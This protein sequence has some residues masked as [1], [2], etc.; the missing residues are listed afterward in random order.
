MKYY[1]I[2]QITNLINGKIYIG[3]HETKIPND[4]YMGSGKN[5]KG[6]INK[7]GLENFKK[8]IL[9][10]F[11]TEEEMNFKEAELVT[12][13]FCSRVDTY[14]I[15]PG[16]KGGW[17]YLNKNGLNNNGKDYNKIGKKLKGRKYPSISEMMKIRHKEGKVKYDTFLG[18]SHSEQTKR[19]MSLKA[20][21]RKTNSQSGTMWITNGS[22]NKKIKNIDIMPDGWYKGR[23]ATQTKP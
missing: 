5:I 16:G 14:N 7:Y 23:I 11:N 20:K 13:D 8:D 15:C 12:E 2:Y 10:I 21:A 6:A 1:I 3:K 9:F 22:E 19:K 18:K 17:G 4:S